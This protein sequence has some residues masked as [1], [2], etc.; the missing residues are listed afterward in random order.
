[1]RPLK[2]TM[3][4]FGPYR[5]QE[6]IDFE[7]LED[8]RLFVISGNTGAGKTSIFD[9]VCF[10]LYGFASGEDR[11]ESRMLR[12]HFAD[13]ETHTSVEFAF[14]IGRRTFR[15]FRQL[16]HRKGV[17]KS[18]TG[19]RIELFETTGGQETPCTDRF[20]VSDV[21]A[22]LE[23][24]IGLSKD[25]F[26]QIVMLPQGEFRKLLTSDTENKE[27]ILRR[28]FRTGMY[29]KLEDRF[30]QKS[31][32]LK[33]ALKSAQL[34]SEV[35]IKQVQAALPAREESA[36]SATLQQEYRSVPQVAEGLEQEREHYLSLAEAAASRRTALRTQADAKESELRAGTALGERF[37]EREQKRAQREAMERRVPELAAQE[38]R[39][40]LAERAAGLAPYE[41][42]RSR[43]AQAADQK[44]A[45]HEAKRRET[46]AAAAALAAAETRHR[47]EAA[48][49]PER[50]AAERELQR[51]GELEPAVR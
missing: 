43:A 25:Q 46:E 39:L 41:E 49:E 17:N 15:V 16:G 45:Q 20:T 13:E 32:E 37:V 51:L 23:S 35:Y 42:Q 14:A 33:E 34:E 8:R 6:T 3:T 7:L 12:S 47:E 44:R 30:Q 10:A 22:N 9:A 40:Q 2:L 18:E 11:F 4:A 27:D 1:M 24:L 29:Q 48:Q 26:S 38:R 50:Q 36:L 21:N 19:A 5:D 31:R 28:I